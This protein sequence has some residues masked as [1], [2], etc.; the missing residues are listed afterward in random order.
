MNIS[1]FLRDKGS[2]PSP[3][4]EILYEFVATEL[5]NSILKQG[6]WTKS[7]SDCDWDEKKAKALYVK[8]RILQLRKSL[9]DEVTK[10]NELRPLRDGP[11]LA[12]QLIKGDF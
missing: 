9:I 3:T 10:Q 8:M 1:D 7:L 6:L 12:Q 2:P 4:D 11:L 5:S